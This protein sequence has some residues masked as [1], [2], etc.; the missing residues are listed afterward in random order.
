MPRRGLHHPP[1]AIEIGIYD[2]VPALRRKIQS[3]LRKLPSRVVDQNVDRPEFLIDRSYEI[4]DLFGVTDRHRHGKDLGT[5]TFEKFLGRRQFL[6]VTSIYRK[7]CSELG[8][9]GRNG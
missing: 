9:Q 6:L 3:G 4:F 7:I 2:S 8:K 1:G 5:Q